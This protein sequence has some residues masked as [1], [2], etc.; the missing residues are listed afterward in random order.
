MGT[1]VTRLTVYSRQADRQTDS[2]GL[3]ISG[4]HVPGKRPRMTEKLAQR[5]DSGSRLENGARCLPSVAAVSYQ[6]SR[7]WKISARAQSG[8]SV[9]CH[10]KSETER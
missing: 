1:D 9:I 4:A 2:T 8:G 5:G 10:S 6:P 3:P 7:G